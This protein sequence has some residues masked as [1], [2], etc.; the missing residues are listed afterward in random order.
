MDASQRSSQSATTVLKEWMGET[1]RKAKK[2]YKDSNKEETHEVPKTSEPTKKTKGK[3]LEDMKAVKATIKRKL[4]SEPPINFSS[5]PAV[6]DARVNLIKAQ[7]ISEVED[8]AEV[9]RVN[10]QEKAAKMQKPGNAPIIMDHL[11]L[12]DEED[13][14]DEVPQPNPSEQQGYEMQQQLY[15]VNTPTAPIVSVYVCTHS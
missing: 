5:T 12:T 11:E 6:V 7:L 4:V 14:Q 9:V 1:K 8:A 3:A 2:E 15:T 10:E 13:E